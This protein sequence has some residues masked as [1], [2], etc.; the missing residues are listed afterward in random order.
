M[1]RGLRSRDESKIYEKV[2]V[3]YVC[4]NQAVVDFKYRLKFGGYDVKMQCGDA[5]Y[6]GSIMLKVSAIVFATFLSAF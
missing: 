5:A 2:K 1:T 3:D 4:I 6:S